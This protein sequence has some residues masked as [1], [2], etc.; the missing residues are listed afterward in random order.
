MRSSVSHTVVCLICCL[1]LAVPGCA[2]DEVSV[3]SIALSDS[4]AEIFLARYLISTCE[5]V[6]K[7]GLSGYPDGVYRCA[8]PRLTLRFGNMKRLPLPDSTEVD[9]T[10]ASHCLERLDQLSCAEAGR[11]G[12][13]RVGCE[14]ALGG[15]AEVGQL[16]PSVLDCKP[17]LV[18]S[19]DGAE[20]G[21]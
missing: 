3:D 16:C 8:S 12:R 4:D 18:C 9:A 6:K 21:V 5:F 7:C 20:S 19:C 17:G 11:L 10:I 1:L 13:I 2:D 15:Q 14:T